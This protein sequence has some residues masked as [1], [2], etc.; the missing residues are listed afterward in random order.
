MTPN[1][2][3]D[4]EYL[5]YKN[6]THFKKKFENVIRSSGTPYYW[7]KSIE[8]VKSKLNTNLPYSENIFIHLIKYFSLYDPFNYYETSECCSYINFWLNNKI[9]ETHGHVSSLMF[10]LFNEFAQKYSELKYGYNSK[11][12]CKPY[13]SYLDPDIYI[14][15]KLL[16]DLYHMYDEINSPPKNPENPACYTLNFILRLY[17]DAVKNYFEHDTNLFNKLKDLKILI[18]ELK[19]ESINDCRSKLSEF[20]TPDEDLEVQNQQLGMKA[21]MITQETL[22]QETSVQAL[23]IP[24]TQFQQEVTE[25]P[26]IPEE[27]IRVETHRK[28]DNPIEPP[29]HDTMHSHITETHA[30]TESSPGFEPHHVQFVS[31][32]TP[33]YPE[34][35]E[36]LQRQEL[37]NEPATDSSTILGSITGVLK[38]VEP[39]PILGVSGGMGALFLLFKVLK[40]KFK[41]ILNYA[42]MFILHL[43][44]NYS[45]HNNYVFKFFIYLFKY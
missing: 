2:K 12:N 26:P 7:E 44:T 40:T 14:K 22:S 9:R 6:Y 24:K 1:K 23:D 41:K 30:K 29:N 4:P 38:D 25:L 8:H 42:H 16:Y 5:N 3:P 28:N 43:N 21:E 18:K 13:L 33:L 11:H 10:Y 36:Y 20:K 31:L 32:R 15:T 39:A 37:S 19:H 27:P 17:K 34:K 35:K 45:E